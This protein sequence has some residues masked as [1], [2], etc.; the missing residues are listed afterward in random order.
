MIGLA[1]V[2]VSPAEA[3]PLIRNHSGSGFQP[4]LNPYLTG[5]SLTKSAVRGYGWVITIVIASCQVQ[6]AM[7]ARLTILKLRKYCENLFAMKTKQFGRD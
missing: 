7:S 6:V 5:S 4:P 2:V 1:T 3:V